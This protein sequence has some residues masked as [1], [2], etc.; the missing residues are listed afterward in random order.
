MDY[1]LNQQQNNNMARTPKIKR[2]WIKE[3]KQIVELL[4]KKGFIKGEFKLEDLYWESYNW[5]NKKC[6]KTKPNP[7]DGKRYRFPIYMPAIYFSTSDYWGESDEHS[8]VDVVLERLYWE[9]VDMTNW[10]SDSGEYPVSTF[11]RMT[12][13]QFIKYLKG[14]PTK[15][16]DNKIK[17][18]LKKTNEY[19]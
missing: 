14:L 4:Y 5:F 19:D 10:D 12:R 6:Y 17:K 13:G 18:V 1:G 2:R 8:V 15:V 7:Y 9:H 3:E 11:P 16:G